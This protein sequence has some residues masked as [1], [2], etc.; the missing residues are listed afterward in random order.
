MRY[1]IYLMSTKMP[2]TDHF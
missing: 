1:I 2:I